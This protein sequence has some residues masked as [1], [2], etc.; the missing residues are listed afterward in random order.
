MRGLA[1]LESGTSK[2]NAKQAKA[3]LAVITVWKSKPVMLDPQAAKV[4]AQ[5]LSYLTPAQK[6]A[7]T[8]RRGPGGGGPGGPG[9]GRPGGGPGGPGGGRPGRFGGGPGGGRPGGFGGGPGGRP[10]GPGGF[11][12]PAP[13]D[14][15]PINP[16]TLPFPPMRQRMQDRETALI[17]ALKATH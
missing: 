6:T 11:T 1:D 9:G 10:G 8:A 13:K 12:M 2:L 3:V 16:S 17:A 7:V 14:Y 15:N 5:L 4:N